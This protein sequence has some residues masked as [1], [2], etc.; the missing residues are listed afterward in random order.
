MPVFTQ[1][2]VTPPLGEG[3]PWPE[4]GMLASAHTIAQESVGFGDVMILGLV[5]KKLLGRGRGGNKGGHTSLDKI[6]LEGVL[7]KK[8]AATRG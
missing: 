5:G 7:A 4:L 6:N 2:Y 3:T 8:G 1:D